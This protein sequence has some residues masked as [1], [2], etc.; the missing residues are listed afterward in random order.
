[1]KRT[2]LLAVASLGLLAAPAVKAAVFV[3]VGPPAPIVETRPAIPGAGYVWTPGYYRWNGGAHVWVNG[4]WALPPRPGA[5]WVA[6]RWERR[7]GGY[8]F[9]E[10]RWR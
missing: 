7:G 1:M 6:H 5:V 8:Y 4:A 9:R 10:G 3:R 2:L